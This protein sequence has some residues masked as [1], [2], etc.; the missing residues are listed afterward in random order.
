MSGWVLVGKVAGWVWRSLEPRGCWKTSRRS[1]HG[2]EDTLRFLRTR[3]NPE[4]SWQH[5]WLDEEQEVVHKAK[6]L[7]KA[8]TNN[9][10]FV[11]KLSISKLLV[12]SLVKGVGALLLRHQLIHLLRG[13]WFL[14][15]VKIWD[16]CPH[17]SSHVVSVVTSDFQEK[18][19]R[20]LRF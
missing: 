8:T 20:D 5:Q 7:I 15:C 13:N 4:D 2:Q 18:N 3:R 14:Y 16:S 10:K 12:D 11:L 17:C 19:S 6:L 9:H 1:D